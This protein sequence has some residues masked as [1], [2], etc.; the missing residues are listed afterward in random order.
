MNMGEE[1]I[2]KILKYLPIK[3][4]LQIIIPNLYIN[5]KNQDLLHNLTN[6]SKVKNKNELLL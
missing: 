1:T 3:C 2:N 4:P 6:S 5:P